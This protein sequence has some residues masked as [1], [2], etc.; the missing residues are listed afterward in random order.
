MAPS[1]KISAPKGG[2]Q[3]TM[4][5]H[6]SSGQVY[7]RWDTKSVHSSMSHL[8]EEMQEEF[9]RW[10]GKFNNW[11]CDGNSEDSSFQ[12]DGDGAVVRGTSQKPKLLKRWLLPQCFR[13]P[14]RW[15]SKD[16]SLGNYF[17]ALWSV[18]QTFPS[19]L[20]QRRAHLAFVS[21]WG[22]SNNKTEIFLFTIRFLWSDLVSRIREVSGVYTKTKKKQS[23]FG[24]H[25]QI[26]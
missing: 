22:F 1:H 18:Q 23:P 13:K 3:S 17:L 6:V 4:D 9:G 24:K 25:L 14:K 26:T 19:A 12:Q 11:L 7:S 10:A 21:G 5:Q 15:P 2:G 8:L 16:C 20:G